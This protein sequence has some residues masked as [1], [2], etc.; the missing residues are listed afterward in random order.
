MVLF[1][2]P[3]LLLAKSSTLKI[4]DFKIT[5]YLQLIWVAMSC[6][7]SFIT[8]CPPPPP[9][10]KP[11]LFTT[12]PTL[13][14]SVDFQSHGCCRK[15]AGIW[16]WRSCSKKFEPKHWWKL[17]DLQKSSVTEDKDTDRKKELKCS[18]FV[19]LQAWWG[20]LP[21]FCFS[22]QICCACSACCADLHFFNVVIGIVLDYLLA[23]GRLFFPFSY[24]LSRR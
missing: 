23:W 22:V 6:C 20:Q 18:N 13:H 19:C 15:K 21:T 16:I 11:N 17:R 24:H 12:L 4:T 10:K 3:F 1:C 8:S 9:K 2:F 7:R 5:V 14:P